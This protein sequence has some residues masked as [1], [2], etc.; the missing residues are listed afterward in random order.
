MRP[1]RGTGGLFGSGN[2]SPVQYF[3]AAGTPNWAAREL[4]VTLMVPVAGVAGVPGIAYV[5]VAGP[6]TVTRKVPLYAGGFAP[7][8]VAYA[9][10]A[11][12]P[13]FTLVITETVDPTSP[14]AD[15]AL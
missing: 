13:W 9:D 14:G 7:A 1:I 8:I 5:N 12:I 6:V 10:C 2:G 4:N 3:A 15:V 11:V